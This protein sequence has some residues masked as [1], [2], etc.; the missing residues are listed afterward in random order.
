MR[1]DVYAESTVAIS[2]YNYVALKGHPCTRDDIFEQLK[3]IHLLEL[4]DDL[5]ERSCAGLIEKKYITEIGDAL[6]VQDP[7]RRYI[8]NRDRS[9]FYVDEER[10]IVMGGWDKWIVKDNQRGY[11]PI[12]EVYK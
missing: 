6:F 2:V 10:G 1:V 8:V 3:T 12:E 7:K 4:D 9:D 11:V 5:F